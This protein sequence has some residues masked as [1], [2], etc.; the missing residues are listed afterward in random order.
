T[1]EPGDDALRDQRA[2]A[3][4]APLRP[5]PGQGQGKA[6]VEM[7]SDAKRIGQ[8]RQEGAEAL[9]QEQGEGLQRLSPTGIVTARLVMQRQQPGPAIGPLEPA[10]AWSFEIGDL[11]RDLV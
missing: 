9:R 10:S 3:V 5:I 11:G 2:Q 8:A 1:V 4:V 7:R 6:G